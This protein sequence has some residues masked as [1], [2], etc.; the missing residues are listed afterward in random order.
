M[1]EVGS[2]ESLCLFA[3]AWEERC[4]S[5]HVS[6][7]VGVLLRCKMFTIPVYQ[8]DMVGQSGASFVFVLGHLP[9]PRC[10]LYSFSSGLVLRRSA[11]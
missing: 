2:Q 11:S 3:T 6:A 5:I 1:G 9:A 4:V 8:G 10:M 7:H